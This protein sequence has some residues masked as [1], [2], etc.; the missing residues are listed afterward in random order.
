VVGGREATKD[1]VNSSRTDQ[2]SSVRLS[3][4]QQQQPAAA[5]TFGDVLKRYMI[6]PYDVRKT[7]LVGGG[8]TQ[9]GIFNRKSLPAKF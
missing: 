8:G 2:I 9:E 7:K 3:M 1:I 5:E 4:K 6:C